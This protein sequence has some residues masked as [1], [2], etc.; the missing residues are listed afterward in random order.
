MNQLHLQKSFIQR[1]IPNRIIRRLALYACCL[2]ALTGSVSCGNSDQEEAAQFFLRGNVQLQKREFR[3]AIRYYTEAIDK[4]ADFADAYNNRGLA[5][6]R[7][8]DRD[9]ALA[10]Y[11][12]AID[13]DPEFAEA[14][15]NRADIWLESNHALRG[16]SDL[17]RI[18]KT[19]TDSTFYQT[20]LGDAYMEL[21]KP[22]QAQAA[23]DKAIRLD[24][25]NVE[26]L[27][28]RGALF[29]QQKA[30]E[31]AGQDLDRA[32]TLNPKQ[33]E[34]L[35]NKA[36]LLANSGQ[37]QQALLLVDQALA[38]RTGQPYYLNNKGYCLLMLNRDG[39]AL[40]VIQEA[41]RKDPA[42]AWAHR[43]LG[44]YYLRQQQP[45]QAISSLTEAGRLDPSVDNL[46]GYSGKAWLLKNDRNKACEQWK[47]G[48]TAGDPMA[49]EL[50]KVQC[51]QGVTSG[52][53]YSD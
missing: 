30:Y 3:E 48:I 8:G 28:N 25:G 13:A 22:G 27:T 6:Y 43:N 14:Y 32:L 9:G 36:L 40:P 19:Y 47:R 7:N 26:A 17:E 51:R 35:N 1:T 38:I 33:P 24:A 16:L 5:R 34:A 45:D 21:K 4:K 12:K 49:Q 52:E 18:E 11:D 42:N 39:E 50:A 10:D 15:L 29:Y 53:T 44:I 23:Y 37:Y 41:L 46:Y 20:R 2:P 31:Q